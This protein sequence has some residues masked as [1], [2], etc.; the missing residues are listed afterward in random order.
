MKAAL[1][2]NC[3]TANTDMNFARMLSCIEECAKNGAQLI[4]FGER[5]YQN[6]SR[7]AVSGSFYRSATMNNNVKLRFQLPCFLLSLS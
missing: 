6:T 3:V 1:V 2:M 5:A 7:G 4:V